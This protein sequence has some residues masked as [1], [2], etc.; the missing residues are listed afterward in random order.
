MDTIAGT[1][2]AK[3]HIL[4]FTFLM[5]QLN[6]VYIFN[7]CKHLKICTNQMTL[8]GE[9]VIVIFHFVSLCVSQLFW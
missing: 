8:G 3:R 4:I 7:F 5:M 6:G 9:S 2:Y 1:L